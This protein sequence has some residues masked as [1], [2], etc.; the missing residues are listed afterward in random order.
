M[1]GRHVSSPPL[2][3]ASDVTGGTRT[4]HRAASPAGASGSQCALCELRFFAL[5]RGS[6]RRR[7]TTV[8]VVGGASLRVRVRVCGFPER[9]SAHCPPRPG[10]RGCGWR[11]S[12]P[13][14]L[15]TKL[16]QEDVQKDG[17]ARHPRPA[18]RGWGAWGSCL[19]KSPGRRRRA[20]LRCDDSDDSDIK[21][22]VR[23]VSH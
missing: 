5:K 14:A 23:K 13:A 18:G 4:A 12:Q 1:W 20:P 8:H 11:G 10:E 2:P 3:R 15:E 19:P 7:E 17:R 16:L 9:P 22:L 6:R 21:R